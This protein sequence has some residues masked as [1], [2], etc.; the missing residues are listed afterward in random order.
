MSNQAPNKK[1]FLS[2][3]LPGGSNKG[4]DNEVL[5]GSLS[6]LSGY[7]T[8][9]GV[10]GSVAPVDHSRPP[11][12][13]RDEYLQTK[14]HVSLTDHMIRHVSGVEAL[15]DL[16]ERGLI[17]ARAVS[18]EFFD[19]L[20]ATTQCKFLKEGAEAYQR[21]LDVRNPNWREVVANHIKSQQEK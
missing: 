18:S 21:V 7:S 5:D 19:K 17:I 8:M 6:G 13:E 4:V 15:V 14:W 2:K 3:L 12:S 10:D 20:P 9:V 1:S 11:P 16:D